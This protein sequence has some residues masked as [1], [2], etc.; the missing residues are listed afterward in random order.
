L[1]I[2]LHDSRAT[3]HSPCAEAGNT[4]RA[5][6]RLTLLTMTIGTVVVTCLAAWARASV[7]SGAARRVSAKTG[8]VGDLHPELDNLVPTYRPK[9]PPAASKEDKRFSRYQADPLAS[10]EGPPGRA[11]R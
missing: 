3:S 1:A 8:E 6:A 11:G 7:A 10:D 9:R 2:S 4:D 5:D